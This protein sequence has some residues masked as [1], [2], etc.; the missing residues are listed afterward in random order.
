MKKFASLIVGLAFTLIASSAA[1]AQVT[2]DVSKITCRQFVTYKISNP[3][4]IAMWISGYYHGTRGD[5]IVD[6][7][8]LIA[9]AKKLQDYCLGKPDELL[10]KAVEGGAGIR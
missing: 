1:R 6:T 3:N 4:Y 9:N 8:A 5:P 7:Q 10:I 2:L